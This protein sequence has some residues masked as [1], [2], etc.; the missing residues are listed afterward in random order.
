[1]AMTPHREDYL[2]AIYSANVK[3]E[4]VTN[5]MLSEFLEI[6][7]PSVSEMLSKLVEANVIMK[8]KAL[9]YVLSER[10]AK[11]AQQ[12]LN[13]HR[14]W[15]V[16][17]VEH[18]GYSWNEVHDDA[19]VLEHATSQLLLDRMNAFLNYPSSCP[20]GSVIYGNEVKGAIT[21]KLSDCS[22]GDRV[23][24]KRIDEV[25]GLVEHLYKKRATLD[26]TYQIISVNGFDGSYE[27][28]DDSGR[29]FSLSDKVCQMIYVEVI[30]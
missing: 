19:E 8:D 27:L 7:P 1:M 30:V 18:L 20:H 12:L 5:K 28:H 14:L 2:K 24:F 9:G 6:S 17:L 22:S 4:K 23:I 3:F 13:K 25:Q 10:G 15:E 11:E 29:C 26:Q 21:I 16:F